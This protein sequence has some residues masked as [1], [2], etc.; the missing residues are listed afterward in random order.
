MDSYNLPSALSDKLEINEAGS[1]PSS[2]QIDKQNSRTNEVS[3]T[4]CCF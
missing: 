1:R 2:E 4:R 3:P